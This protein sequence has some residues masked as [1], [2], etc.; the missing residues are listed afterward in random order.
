MRRKKAS[1]LK[2]GDK[3]MIDG[4]LCEI[5]STEL[6]V[7][8]GKGGKGKQKAKKCRIVA[9]VLGTKETKVSV[10]PADALIEVQ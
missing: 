5:V 9:I 7:G 4:A 2:K 6:S 8:I 10:K 3:A 1:E